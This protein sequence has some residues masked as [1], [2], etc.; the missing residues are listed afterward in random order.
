MICTG[1]WLLFLQGPSG[2]LADIPKFTELEFIVDQ[3]V[4]DTIKR[5]EQQSIEIVGISNQYLQ[6]WWASLKLL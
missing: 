6:K 4:I 1:N 2:D 3:S 5:V